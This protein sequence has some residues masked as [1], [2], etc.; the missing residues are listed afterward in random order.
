[1]KSSVSSLTNHMK[2]LLKWYE[3]DVGVKR[4]NENENDYNEM[5]RNETL[6]HLTIGPKYHTL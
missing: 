5:F 2:V 3:S 1:M 6:M 4:E